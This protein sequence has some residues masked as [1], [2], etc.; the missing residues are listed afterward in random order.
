MDD[1]LRFDQHISYM[2]FKAEMQLNTLGLLQKYMEKS[3][4]IAIVNT[5]IYVN[6]NYC[7]LLWEK[8]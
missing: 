8:D 5:F 2:C 1:L 4:K 3:E 6:F 7:L